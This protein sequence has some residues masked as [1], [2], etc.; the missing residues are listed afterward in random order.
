MR[1]ACVF[2]I[3]TGCR[4]PRLSP[5]R[6][7]VSA[8]RSRGTKEIVEAGTN[9]QVETAKRPQPA[10]LQTLQRSEARCLFHGRADARPSRRPDPSK[11]G[12]GSE[13]TGHAPRVEQERFSDVAVQI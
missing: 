8:Q 7:P 9:G 1:P 12:P 6:G 5:W 4:C 11:V 13:G 2:S 3:V 10:F